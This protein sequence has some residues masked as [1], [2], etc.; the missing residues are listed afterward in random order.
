MM[1]KPATTGRKWKEFDIGCEKMPELP[2][3]ET[4]RRDLEQVLPG[5]TFTDVKI[6]YNGS[7]KEPSAYAIKKGLPG[8]QVDFIDRRGKYLLF[9]LHDSTVM[10][11]HLRMTGRLLLFRDMPALDKHSHVI[12]TFDNHA[13]LIFHDI[14][15]FGTIYWLPEKRLD[16][17]KG[18][19]AL[20]PEPLTEEFNT[21]YLYR[22]A[23]KRRGQIKGMLLN[24]SIVAGLGNIYCDEAL[25]L[26]GIRPDRNSDSISAEECAKLCRAIK[27]V[28]KKAIEKR[29]TTRSDY[30]DAL[31]NYGLFQ[32]HLQVYGRTGKPC[33][34]C[35]SMLVRKKIAGRS[36][37]F[38]PQCQK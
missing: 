20:G 6:N 33:L 7:I 29:G 27:E 30:R 5:R 1:S 18:L 31:G 8:R 25:F 26:A 23:K 2:E 9:Y 28:L 15:K 35:G 14:R 34:A 13:C 21:N 32:N 11:I 16:I 17:V 12:F 4:I 22:T 19:S 3:V 36:S 37:H 10:V 24:Q 38:C